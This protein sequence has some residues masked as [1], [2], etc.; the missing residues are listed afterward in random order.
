[1]NWKNWAGYYAVVSYDMHHDQEYFAYR[2]AAGL[3]DVTPLF[4]Y[5]PKI[6]TFYSYVLYEFISRE[7][8]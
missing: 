3:M 7:F 4:K 8:R 2:H 5:E 1:M 6:P